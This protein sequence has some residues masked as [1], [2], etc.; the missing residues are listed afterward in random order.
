MP[1][2]QCL[3]RCIMKRSI[4]LFSLILVSAI[5]SGCIVSTSPDKNVTMKWNESKEFK[6]TAIPAGDCQWFVDGELQVGVTASSFVYTPAMKKPVSAQEVHT[7]EVKISGSSYIWNVTVT[8]GNLISITVTPPC[9]W[10]HPG[11][12][13][14]LSA[15]A[16]YDYGELDITS[17]ATWSVSDETIATVNNA[18]LHAVGL[19][20]IATVKAAFGGK[21]GTTPVTVTDIDLSALAVTPSNPSVA[22]GVEQEF[23]ATG[24]FADSSQRDITGQVE[25]QSRNISVAR[26]NPNER[27]LMSTYGEGTAII[28]AAAAGKMGFTTLSV[29]APVLLGIEV[30]PDNPS[31]PSGLS[32]AFRVEATYTNGK[33]TITSGVAWSSSN[34]SVVTI[35]ANGLAQSQ[36]TGNTT[37][38]AQ[39]EG[40]TDTTEITVTAAALNK[41]TVAP[42]TPTIP[43]GLSIQFSA[44]GTYTDNSVYDITAMVTWNSKNTTVAT[45]SST[46]LASA[47]V[48]GEADIEA[49]MSGIKGS[50]KLTVN[51]AELLSI[52]IMPAAPVLA[53]G[54]S[55][56]FQA[57][58]TYTDGTR[59]ITEAVQWSSDNPDVA[60]ITDKGNA[61]FG[62]TAGTARIY[63]EKDGKSVWTT[64]TFNEAALLCIEVAPA[65]QS[66][67]IGGTL[68]LS[69]TG[70]KE[71]GKLYTITNDVLWSSS[72]PTIATIDASGVVTG[73]SAG[74]VTITATM[75]GVLGFTTVTVN[76]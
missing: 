7:I 51:A 22:W 24:L 66:I 11:E 29:T 57:L 59:D 13:R 36:G 50:T 54:V 75:D 34:T 64:I 60:K 26:V 16:D 61:T 56:D 67:T 48:V 30:K 39:Y 71:D 76:P 32:Q 43:K 37:I 44:I 28:E 46:G 52:E 53:Y 10:L 38:S 35:D 55:Q 70:V 9:P 49:A 33:K 65:N 58:G 6:V 3:R 12:N 4:Y 21:E 69:A 40:F 8:L 72:N 31:I 20:G 18:E 68:Q 14:S 73:V 41:I 1:R 25:W 45:I 74:S 5:L 63:A 17:P 62:G 19:V 23:V 2:C 15:E 42:A 27:G 47:Q